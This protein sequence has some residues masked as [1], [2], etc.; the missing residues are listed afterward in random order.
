MSAPLPNANSLS[1][2]PGGIAQQQPSGSALANDFQQTYG[3]GQQGPTGEQ[4]GGH[5]NRITKRWEADGEHVVSSKQNGS[6]F[7]EEVGEQIK[8]PSFKEQVMGNAKKFAGKTFGKDHEVAVGEALLQ[9]QGKD[10]AVAA[11]Q[12]AKQ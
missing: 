1:N 12:S 3:E 7:P 2:Q 4:Q 9:G 6:T 8:K 5:Y 11:G 10:N